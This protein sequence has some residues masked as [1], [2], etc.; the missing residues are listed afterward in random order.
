MPSHHEAIRGRRQ[1]KTLVSWPRL[2][3]SRTGL[4]TWERGSLPAYRRQ[5]PRTGRVR[6]RRRPTEEPPRRLRS[7]RVE[8]TG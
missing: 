3:V 6:N 7:N 4:R 1:A 5:R 2:R 8:A